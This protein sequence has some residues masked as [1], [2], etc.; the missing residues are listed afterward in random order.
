MHRTLAYVAA[1][2]LFIGGCVE[3]QNDMPS[4]EDVKAAHEHVL[5]QPPEKIQHPNDGQLEDKLEYLGIDIDTDTVTPGK[6][7]TL[8]HYWRVLNPVGDDW[9]IF[10]HLETPD[11]KK[12][13]LNADH[14]PIGGKYPVSLWKKGEIIRDVH[15]VSVPQSWPGNEVD[16]Y[17]GAWKGPLRLKT[18]KGQHDTENRLLAVKIP[19]QAAGS[20]VEKKRIV[21]KRVKN[22][23][24]KL[25]GKLDEK[26][27]ADAPSTGEFVRTMDG[28]PA[29]Q[30]TQAKM[31]WDDK[32]LYVAFVN[33]DKDIWT[34]LD[35]HDDKLWTQEADEMFIDADGDGKTYVELQVN[36]KGVTFDSFLPTYRQNQNDW[37]AGL[38]AAVTVDGTLNKREDEDKKW[39]VELAIPLD[40]VKGKE[41][42]M[43][44]VPPK[45]GTEWRVN[46]FRMDQ[47]N[48]RPQ[49]GSGWS[50]PMVGDFH[51]LDKFGVLI[52]GDDKAKAPN[53]AA[54]AAE[55]P[56]KA[57]GDK[58]APPA[59]KPDKKGDKDKKEE[60][61]SEAP[62]AEK[63]S[64]AA[65]NAAIRV[66]LTPQ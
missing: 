36:P 47:P 55:G 7:F 62:K 18:T 57:E 34:T 25:D 4:E 35:K 40:A 64:R 51:A 52:F 2:A 19:V 12:N 13:H 29:E 46:F 3:Q 59:G 32:F 58:G 65:A 26:D 41:K 17:V 6:A 50:P 20:A 1:A 66:P 33:D 42:E 11:S 14:V 48:G 21:A 38:K 44:N 15:R 27:W 8:T 54:P 39:I 61:K 31:L 60:K 10:I 30:K 23:A 28:Q 63:S 22:G 5:S 24:I 9:K 49:S 16:I 45:V 56:K 43:K 37:D 53:A